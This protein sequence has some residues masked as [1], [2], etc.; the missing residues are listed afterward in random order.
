MQV[1]VLPEA[2]F[3]D[4]SV[5]FLR[6]VCVRKNAFMLHEWLLQQ[7]LKCGCLKILQIH[8]PAACSKISKSSCSGVAQRMACW[9]HNPKVRGSKPCSATYSQAGSPSSRM[10]NTTEHACATALEGCTRVDSRAESSPQPP[11]MQGGALSMRQHEHV[12]WAIARITRT[13][14]PETTCV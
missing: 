9:A 1:R 7:F 12:L 2:C 5:L 10:H 13:R 6:P 4:A 14:V 8:V 11:P 3:S